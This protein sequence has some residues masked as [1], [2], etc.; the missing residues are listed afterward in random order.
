MAANYTR[1]TAALPGDSGRA[2]VPQMTHTPWLFHR[3]PNAQP[4]RAAGRSTGDRAILL[5]GSAR[6]Q[7]EHIARGDA[8]DAVQVELLGAGLCLF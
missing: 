4:S 6:V 8:L 5:R 1:F 3:V 2:A 7:P